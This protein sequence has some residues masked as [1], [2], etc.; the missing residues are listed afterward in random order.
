MSETLFVDSTSPSGSP[1]RTSVPTA[2]SVTNTMSPKA[3]WAYAVIPTRTALSMLRSH[4]CSR[5]YCR[6]S[7]CSVVTGG[8]RTARSTP[9]RLDDRAPL[10]EQMSG[11]RRVRPLRPD[12]RRCLGRVGQH[13]HPAAVLLDD[14]HAVRRVDP[15]SCGGLDDSAHDHAFDCP[16][17]RH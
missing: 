10:R 6:S 9:G 1:A 11:C 13:Q 4:S 2:G 7:G 3:S 8:E 17:S 15:F 14:P 16:W 5:V 12:V